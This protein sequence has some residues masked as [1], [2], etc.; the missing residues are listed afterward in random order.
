M[1]RKI[2]RY[3]IIKDVFMERR[4]FLKLVAATTGFPFIKTYANSTEVA[5]SS[6]IP[7]LVLEGTPRNRGNIHGESLR[8]QIQGILAAWREMLHAAAGVESN[9]IIQDIMA[10][11][12]FKKAALRY[13][14]ELW[15]ELEGVA[16]GADV[17]LDDLFVLNMPDEHRWYLQAKQ[18]GIALAPIEQCT[19]LG[20]A[21]TDNTPTLMGQNMDIPSASEGFEVLLDIRDD[22]TGIHSMVFSIVGLVGIIGMN[23]QPLGIGNN[24]LKQ[25]A[26]SVNGLPINSSCAAYSTRKCNRGQWSSE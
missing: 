23:N 20:F 17:P 6:D 24:S 1:K 5:A 21:P 7:V 4:S 11:T 10:N 14:P 12:G 19:T 3:T 9:L 8:P 16:E 13:T 26:V 2:R 18:A 22:K 15:D 25:L